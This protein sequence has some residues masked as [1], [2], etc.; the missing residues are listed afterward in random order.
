MQFYERKIMNWRTMR[1]ARY[2]LCIACILLSAYAGAAEQ[3]GH[4][5]LLSS[6]L[7]GTPAAGWLTVG[8]QYDGDRARAFADA[9]PAR[10]ISAWRRDGRLGGDD[11]AAGD[12][13]DMASNAGDSFTS[14]FIPPEINDGNAAQAFFVLTLF[15][16]IA[17]L[18]QR[19]RPK[20]P[21]R[22]AT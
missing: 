16:V 7:L 6:D 19:S 9:L 18:R 5:L 11:L 10:G 4:R 21:T 14:P 15:S 20:H 22:A 1:A 13:Y 2:A 3:G 17:C 12:D 8:A